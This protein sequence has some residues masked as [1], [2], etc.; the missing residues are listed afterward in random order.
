VFVE[1]ALPIPVARSFTYAVPEL[2]RAR[3][4]PGARVLVPFGRSERVGWIE[5]VAGEV[6]AGQEGIR[7]LNGVL[8]TRPVL[9]PKL[10]QLCRWI[11][12]Y[13]VASL[14]QVIRSAVPAALTDSSADW[15]ALADSAAGALDLDS[16]SP[17]EREVMEWLRGSE[18]PRSVARLRRERGER[19]WWPSIRRLVEAGVLVVGT[20]PPRVAPPVR[21]RRVVR[22]TAELPSLVERE[23][24]F[25]RAARQRECF[26]TL[27][28]MSGAAELAHLTGALG[29][30]ASVPRALVDK[31]LA[32]IEEE[33]V[34]R[35]PY[36]TIAVPPAPDLIPTEPQAAAIAALIDAARSGD[37]GTWLLRGVTGSGKTLVYIELLR[38]VVERQGRT[39]IVLVPEIALTPQTVGRFKA[40]FGDSVAVLHSALGDGER[41]DEWRAL[42][43]GEKRIVVGARSAIFAP[44]PDLG[45]IVV[46][47]EHE[48]SYKQGEA[49][50]Y[51]AREVA[52]VRAR[53][54]GALCL[55]GSATPALETW[56]NVQNGKFRLLELPARVAGRPL[57][58]VRVVDMRRERKRQ[59]DAPGP[60][61]D[62]SPLVLSAELESAIT[63]RLARGEQ[64][65]L[66]L[67]RRGYSTFVQCRE[68]GQVWH[69]PACN[70]SLTYHR[71]RGRLTCHH[72]FH[73]EAKPDRCSR[74]GSVDIGF[75]GVGTEQVERT[76]ADTFASARIARMDVDTTSGKWSHHR[77]LDRVGRG[78]I[79]ILLGTQMIAKGLDFPEVTLVG[80]INADVGIN[81][82]DFRATER[83]FQ[84]LT[85]VAG[86]A[87]R[88]VKGGEV[89]IQTS[90]PEHYAITCAVR[91]EFD[92]FARKEFD[93]RRQPSYPP[94]CRLV[95]IVASGLEE[96]PTQDLADAA[97]AWLNGL[98][99]RRGIA[100]IDLVGP[101]PCPI[102][103]IRRRWRWHFLLRAENPR[104]LGPV[105]R[106]FAER[107]VPPRDRNQLR[108]AIDRDP[109]A[110][111]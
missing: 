17:L 30:S 13:Y 81:L 6:A 55:F 100:G 49:P 37:P 63:A 39:A 2:L 33:E 79:D 3:A 15:I 31:G 65:I 102:D 25:A 7:E 4:V 83:T 48:G 61:Q 73:E 40:V 10:L 5:R 74:C 28:G 36:A 111:L 51:H 54:E 78:E 62:R 32:R 43:A 98:L 42:R 91:H 101:A 69:C 104:L 87:G 35:D 99:Q 109:V 45:A 27:E 94:F 60:L 107:F 77:I 97:A 70:V 59:R 80:V 72:C 34:S 50:R 108:I 88:G 52:A 41:F 75:R 89:I 85:Q 84:L 8:D 23:R 22:L 14:G 96:R 106:Y 57:P 53:L 18:G 47:E 24:V 1:V 67:N 29:F 46:D 110:L 82:P 86:R 76:V 19:A 95:N 92:E 71:R 90:L 93:A 9:V 64:S 12:D 20:D 105:L 103:R 38:E 26:E 11:A 58:A 16:L 68:C 66:L 56:H 44:L 21:L